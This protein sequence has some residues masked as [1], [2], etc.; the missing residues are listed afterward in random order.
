[1]TR[2][3]AYSPEEIAYSDRARAATRRF[4]EQHGVDMPRGTYEPGDPGEC[5]TNAWRGEGSYVEGIVY[6]EDGTYGGTHAWNLSPLGTVIERTPAYEKVGRYVGIVI[7]RRGAL[8]APTLRWTGWRVSILEA[9]LVSTT[10][11]Q[12]LGMLRSLHRP[13]RAERRRKR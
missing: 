1:V 7:D 2:R 10:P 11:A 5:W 12:V 13:S 3:D 9:A 6:A 4:V 8:A